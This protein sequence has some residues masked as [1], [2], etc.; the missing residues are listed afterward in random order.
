MTPQICLKHTSSNSRTKTRSQTHLP[1]TIFHLSQGKSWNP[2]TLERLLKYGILWP[3]QLSWN[4]PLL[5]VQKP[6]IDDYQPVKDL[7]A[8]NQAT[9]NLHQVL[10]NPFEAAFF[11]CLDLKDA[12]FCI[13]PRPRI[14]QSLSSN[15]KIW[16][17]VKRT[18]WHV[19]E[20]IKD[21]KILQ[22]PSEFH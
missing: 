10:P 18:S 22:Q 21:S 12:F 2:E 15:E 11:T 19:L 20:C 17:M 5:P 13:H 3:C 14:N 4:M 8:V 16:K 1:E 6:G 9:V 7:W